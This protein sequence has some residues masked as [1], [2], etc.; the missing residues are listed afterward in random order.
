MTSAPKLMWHGVK[1][2]GVRTLIIALILA[3]VSEHAYAAKSEAD[4]GTEQ[5][6]NGE[7]SGCSPAEKAQQQQHAHE[8]GKLS[9][10]EQQEKEKGEPAVDP[11]QD[12]ARRAAQNVK[13]LHDKEFQRVRAESAQAG[14]DVGGDHDVLQELNNRAKTAGMGATKPYDVLGVSASATRSEIKKAYRRLSLMLHP[15][16][17]KDAKLKDI[18]N[19]VFMDIVA[20]YEV[21]GNED[22]R[23]VRTCFI[24]T[25]HMC[26]MPV[27]VCVYLSHVSEFASPN[28]CRHL[29]IWVMPT[30]PRR[31]PSTP[32]GISTHTNTHTHY[33]SVSG[34]DNVN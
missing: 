22:K 13:E 30:A 29:T 32:I 26:A 17:I 21:L 3:A 16:K 19:T 28:A 15:D 27:S 11:M 31:K 12:A 8:H 9:Q 34:I 2:R 25:G 18:A 24:S 4:E 33:R 5:C 23:Q 14:S 7:G 6:R 20:A 1:T 10:Q